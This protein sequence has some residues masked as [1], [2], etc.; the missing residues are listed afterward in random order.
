MQNYTNPFNP[1]TSITF[2]IP[3]FSIVSIGIYNVNGQKVKSLLQGSMSPG[4]HQISWYGDDESGITVSNG[5]YFYIMETSNFV[6]K[7][8]MLFIK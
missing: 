8:K 7:R 2:S 6:E 4:Y 5:I 1:S 3:E